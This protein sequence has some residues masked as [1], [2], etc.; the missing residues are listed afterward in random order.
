MEI[1]D[2]S[3]P[4]SRGKLDEVEEDRE[5]VQLNVITN[6]KRNDNISLQLQ[7]T[8]LKDV[9]VTALLDSGAQGRF[10]D[11]SVIGHGKIRRLNKPI[12]VRNVDGT[13]NAAGKIVHEARL[14]YSIGDQKFD[15]WFLVTSLGDQK[16][17]LGMPWLET[18]N[19]EI[20]W[21]TKTIKLVDWSKE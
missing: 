9:D 2:E 8:N 19:P 13:R 3:T 1:E 5:D 7:Q 20:N 16:V 6:S 10:V 14:K 11:E 17:I 18:H 15:E 4:F 21:N 12:M